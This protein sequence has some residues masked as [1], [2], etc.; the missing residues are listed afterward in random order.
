MTMVLTIISMIPCLIKIYKYPMKELFIY[1][2]IYCQLCSYY[3]GWHVHE[4]AILTC[5]IPMTY[6][7]YI[8]I[9]IIII[10][11]SLLCCDSSFDSSLYMLLNTIGAVTIAPL[12]FP[13]QEKITVFF[14]LFT[15]VPLIYFILNCYMKYK[16]REKYN[17][18]LLLYRNYSQI[19]IYYDKKIIVAYLGEFC[20]F[21]YYLISD[22]IP[23][24]NKR[25]PFL[26]LLLI[27]VYNSILLLF[28]FR[29][30]WKC[31]N[32]KIISLEEETPSPR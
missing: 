11:H 1:G 9:M 29:F 32:R 8:I 16:Q 28:S 12:L 24:M 4:K 17:H 25:Y 21:I 27:S 26:P 5:L 20:V 13:L 14:L 19:G 10:I 7:N 2:L 6:Y 31:M 23:F 22:Y 18:K 30:I 3:F 15:S